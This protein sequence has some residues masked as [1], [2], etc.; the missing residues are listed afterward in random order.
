MRCWFAVV[1]IRFYLSLEERRHPLKAGSK[2]RILKQYLSKSLL[3]FLGNHLF[4]RKNL[5][6]RERLH[7][8]SSCIIP[9]SCQI[10]P[11]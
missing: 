3:D 6:L 10:A 7:S 5:P 9:Y 4:I 2:D 11:A 1:T 8:L